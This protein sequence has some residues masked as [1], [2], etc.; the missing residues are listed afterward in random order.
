MRQPLLAILV[1][2][3]VLLSYYLAHAIPAEGHHMMIAAPSPYAIEVGT[4]VAKAGGNVV[5]VSVAVGLTLAV[6]S[7]YFAA[8]GGGGFARSHRKPHRQSFI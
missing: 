1:L 3:F 5:D 6:T 8:L 2:C 4:E 7:P